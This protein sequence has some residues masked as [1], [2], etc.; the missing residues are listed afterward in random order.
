M[1]TSGRSAYLAQG[2]ALSRWWWLK[3]NFW[4]CLC[5]C[6]CFRV[7]PSCHSLASTAWGN[8]HTI[9]WRINSSGCL[10]L[11]TGCSTC[12]SC[13]THSAGTGFIIIHPNVCKSVSLSKETK[14]GLFLWSRAT[15][16]DCLESSYFKEKPLRESEHL[17][18]SLQLESSI[19]WWSWNW[20]HRICLLCLCSLRTGA[21]ANVPTPS[22]QASCSPCR[23]RREK[24]IMNF[25]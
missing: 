22:Q 13:T 19:L 8:S 5:V 16:K 11:D 21:D 10:T 20:F 14:A 15:A 3:F 25:I 18:F 1:K 24:I 17:L 9:T 23:E 7:S 6:M 4:V 2:L 12:S